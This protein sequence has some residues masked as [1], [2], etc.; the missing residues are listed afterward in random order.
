MNEGQYKPVFRMF[1]A[2]VSYH[3]LKSLSQWVDL[4]TE[5]NQTCCKKKCTF[6][7]TVSYC[8]QAVPA[9]IAWSNCAFC[10]FASGFRNKQ[11]KTELVRNPPHCFFSLIFFAVL[12]ST[13]SKLKHFNAQNRSKNRQRCEQFLESTNKNYCMCLVNLSF[14]NC[15]WNPKIVSGIRKL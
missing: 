8:F 14:R 12:D 10:D 15:N 3:S 6:N 1:W 7:T 4:F 2:F 13:D 11:K 9:N 5:T